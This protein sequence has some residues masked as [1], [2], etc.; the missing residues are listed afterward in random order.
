MIRALLSNVIVFFLLPEFL[1]GF[2]AGAFFFSFSDA[3]ITSI[4]CLS[5]L[6]ASR[7]VRRV[8]FSLLPCSEDN[9]LYWQLYMCLIV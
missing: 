1:N 6:G 4:N 2:F 8:A 5:L 3:F 9:Y 7:S